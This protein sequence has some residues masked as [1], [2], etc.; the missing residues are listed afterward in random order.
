VVERANG[1]EREVADAVDVDVV[2]VVAAAVVVGMVR[3]T[4]GWFGEDRSWDNSDLGI[5]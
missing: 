2:G 1:A 5:Q 3:L 4:R